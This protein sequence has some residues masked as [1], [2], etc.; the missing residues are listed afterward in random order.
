MEIKKLFIPPRQLEQALNEVQQGNLKSGPLI[1]RYFVQC[2]ETGKAPD[3]R[4]M[5]F[6]SN[7][8]NKGLHDYYTGHKHDL[9]KAIGIPYIKGRP[10]MRGLGEVYYAVKYGEE[11][12]DLMGKK[13][14]GK[15]SYLNAVM[16]VAERH[17][18]SISTIK[19]YYGILKKMN[20]EPQMTSPK[21]D[22]I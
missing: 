13:K 15:V 4:A 11:V 19:T 6:L 7:A 16:I 1:L 22:P 10:E 14:D 2:V 5:N 3:A 21:N 9:N 8:I 20:S 17:K 18:L 12:K